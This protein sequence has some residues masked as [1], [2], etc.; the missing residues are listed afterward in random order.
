MATQLPQTKKSKYSS[1]RANGNAFL[2]L[3]IQVPRQTI[4]HRR[5][6][7][8][9]N[10][11]VPSLDIDVVGHAGAED[12]IVE[13]SRWD[14]VLNYFYA[15]FTTISTTK[16]ALKTITDGFVLHKDAFCGSAFNLL[17]LFM[18]Y[19]LLISFIFL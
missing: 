18:A 19:C 10:V 15:E 4:C 1:S 6:T 16:I 17:D 14:V 11:S 8:I 9:A 12:P 2:P 5:R 13:R 7:F 3:V